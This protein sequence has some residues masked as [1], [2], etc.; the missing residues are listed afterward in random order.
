M[1][2]ILIWAAFNRVKLDTAGMEWGVIIP[3]HA[4]AAPDYF[5]SNHGACAAQYAGRYK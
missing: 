2:P 1:T 4:L 5:I 3:Y